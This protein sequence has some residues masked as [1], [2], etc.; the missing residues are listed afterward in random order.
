MNLNYTLKPSTLS[1]SSRLYRD[2][3]D[4]LNMLDML[5]QVRSRTS[6]WRYWHVGE[7]LWVF[8]MVDCHL[9]PQECIRLWH[10]AEGKL[11]G[12][13]IL[14]EDPNFDCQVLP[15][16]E[17]C[18]IEQEALI[19]VET[20]L[21][22]LRRQGEQQ[23]GGHLVSGAREDD[24]KRIAF[25]EQHGF[26]YCGDFAEVNMLRSME[27]PI[28]APLLSAGCQ[29]RALAETGELAERAAIQRAVWQPWSVGNVS[30]DQYARFTRLPGYRRDLDVVTVAADGAMAAYVNGWVD[31]LNRIGDFGPVGALSAY[32]RQGLTRAALLESLHRMQ[33]LGMERVCI[34][35][36]VS[37]D[38]AI[39]LYESI[40]FRIVNRY[41]DY[42]KG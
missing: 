9:N 42:V 20:R 23:W 6:D 35:T 21:L 26:C 29:V 34:S 31:P 10:S 2:E 32:R 11:V 15:E 38:A 28:P 18:G 36:G 5:M 30:A 33:A 12:F 16:Y 22:E 14:G 8:F 40:G 25:L 24:P 13:A 27:Q 37:N 4:L 7:L 17:W 39:R 3:S 19:W 1:F 41:L